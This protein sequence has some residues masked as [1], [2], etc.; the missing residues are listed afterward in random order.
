MRLFKK[1]SNRTKNEVLAD[2]A[3]LANTPLKRIKGLLGKTGLKQ[4]QGMIITPCSSIH[5]FFMK[6]AID[7]VFLDKE[8][9]TVAMAHSLPPSRL[10]G[11][12]FKASLVVE[13]PPGTLSRT[14]TE[15]NDKISIE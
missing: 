4:G 12:P 8:G 1:V 13:L 14:R 9:N 15:L 7:I 5:T 10:F 2:S 6:F 3:E 11:A